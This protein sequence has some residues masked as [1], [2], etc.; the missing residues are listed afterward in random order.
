MQHNFMMI[1]PKSVKF[2]YLLSSLVS[3]TLQPLKKTLNFQQKIN[4]T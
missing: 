4:Q 2:T 3:N 1:I